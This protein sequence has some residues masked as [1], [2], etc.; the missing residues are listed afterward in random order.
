MELITFIQLTN[1]GDTLEYKLNYENDVN[2]FLTNVAAHIDNVIY[3]FRFPTEGT[4]KD[5]FIIKY[6]GNK[7]NQDRDVAYYV[8]IKQRESSQYLISVDDFLTTFIQIG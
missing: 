4:K 2:Y 7:Q 3:K 6:S 8:L 5:K 1:E